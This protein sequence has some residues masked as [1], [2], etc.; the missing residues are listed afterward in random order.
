MKLMTHV[1][2]ARLGAT[3]GTAL[4]LATVPVAAAH[5]TVLLDPNS[6][7]GCT[8]NGETHAVVPI[9]DPNGV[10]AHTSTFTADTDVVAP[11]SYV[12]RHVVGGNELS[13]SQGSVELAP[14]TWM[15]PA[16]SFISDM[17]AAG[18]S[19]YTIEYYGVYGGARAGTAM[20]SVTFTIPITKNFGKSGK[21]SDA[22]S[23][24]R[25]AVSGTSP[26]GKKN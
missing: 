4:L 5:A 3:V 16:F 2:R 13:T 21:T 24:S 26:A 12:G 9:T 6:V 8:I 25:E 7:A 23:R 11:Y 19:A 20:C 10:A 17:N 22:S 1:L 15:G 18:V 14:N